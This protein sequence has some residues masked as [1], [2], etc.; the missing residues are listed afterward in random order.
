MELLTIIF[1]AFGLAMDAFAVSI[2]SG[3]AY[4]KLH[5]VHTLRIAIFFGAF[6]AIMPLIGFFAGQS[7]LKYIQNW[8]HWISFAILSFVGIKMIYEAFQLEETTKNPAKIDVL[9]IL[10]L[11]TSLDALAVGFTLSLIDL[12][13]LIE[14]AIIGIV[15]F[16][17]SLAGVEIGK[18]AG[19]LFDRKVEIFGGAILIAI[20]LKILIQH[21]T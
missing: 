7:S 16:I 17:L 18:K 6:Q 11:A 5:I 4:K 8:D 12:N 21:F 14:I 10:A 9:L 19:H 2:A 20:G 1:I 3:A 15:T 13:I